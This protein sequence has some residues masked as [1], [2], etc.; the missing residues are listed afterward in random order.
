MVTT[1]SHDYKNTNDEQ[2]NRYEV[3]LL[4]ASKQAGVRYTPQT[5]S[6]SRNEGQKDTYR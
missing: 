5:A 6:K 4:Q 3:L 1:L 2:Q